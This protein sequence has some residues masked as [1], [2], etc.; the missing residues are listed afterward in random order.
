MKYLILILFLLPIVSHAQVCGSDTNV[1]YNN[2]GSCGA[3]SDFNYAQSTGQLYIQ[4]DGLHA[5]ILASSTS[6]ALNIEGDTTFGSAINIFG[7]ANPFNTSV[8]G[9]NIGKV[10]APTANGKIYYPFNSLIPLFGNRDISGAYAIVGV[11]TTSV[12]VQSYTGTATDIGGIAALF[13]WTGGTAVNPFGFKVKSP[14]ITGGTVTGY[15]GIEVEDVGSFN[16]IKTGTGPSIFGDKISVKGFNNSASSSPASTTSCTAGDQTWDKAY[17]Y[18]C[19]HDNSWRR[20]S[21]SSY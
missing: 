1:Q 4:N 15:K 11:Y 7:T 9:L 8:T 18:V 14:V 20:S 2:G 3:N 12:P 10:F 6:N 5:A 21:L 16:A 17:I 19:V 13:Q